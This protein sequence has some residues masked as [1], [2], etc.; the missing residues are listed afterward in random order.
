MKKKNKGFS[1]IEMVV[2]VAIL[3]IIMLAI[4][5][6]LSAMSKNFGQSQKEVALQDSMQQ[7]YS[8]VS[9]V[10]KSAQVVESTKHT[11][12]KKAGNEYYILTEKYDQTKNKKPLDDAEAYIIGLDEDNHSL[13]LRRI[14]YSI[15]N[16]LAVAEA[17]PSVA[18]TGEATGEKN[19]EDLII[20]GKINYSNLYS[21][22]DIYE[23]RYL[24][25]RN[26]KSFSI[27]TGESTPNDANKY[28][29]A[30]YVIVNLELEYGGRTASI[31]QNVFLRNTIDYEE[32]TNEDDDDKKDENK[33][34]GE[35]SDDSEDDDED[36]DEEFTPFGTLDE[37]GVIPNDQIKHNTNNIVVDYTHESIMGTEI[38]HYDTKD[39]FVCK[40]CST[41]LTLKSENYWGSNVAFEKCSSCGS[42]SQYQ[43]EIIVGKN[44]CGSVEDLKNNATLWKDTCG[45]EQLVEYTSTTVPVYKS[46]NDGRIIIKNVSGI[47]DYNTVEIV[48]YLEDPN[49]RFRDYEDAVNHI[50]AVD[51]NLDYE[52]E[53][54]DYNMTKHT[55]KY[56]KIKINNIKHSEDKRVTEDSIVFKYDWQSSSGKAPVVC[57]HSIIAK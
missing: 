20:E 21:L 16:K 54:A 56:I 8:I 6:L 57:T 11:S 49:D 28:L 9:D 39:I 7:T 48:L 55:F 30:G 26:V 44:S 47:K 52:V 40:K 42:T 19:T 31:S 22:K 13:Y 43:G 23:S 10:V 3:S 46:S 38:D 27:K 24:L 36:E 37:N 2:S 18:P 32:D 33:E 14:G 53:V 12:I 51:T 45:T 1:L 15:G 41:E 34:E 25:A 5:F 4:G 50:E 17:T 35:K 29:D